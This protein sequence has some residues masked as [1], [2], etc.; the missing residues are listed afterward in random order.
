VDSGRAATV[1]QTQRPREWDDGFTMGFHVMSVNVLAGF[2]LEETI[3]SSARVR[4]LASIDYCRS[5]GTVSP[6]LSRT[7]EFSAV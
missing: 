6:F 3:R 7:T 5:E 1:K 2:R 4:V